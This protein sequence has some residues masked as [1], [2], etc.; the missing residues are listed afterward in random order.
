MNEQKFKEFLRMLDRDCFHKD[1]LYVCSFG[2]T[3]CSLEVGEWTL[4]KLSNDNK[5]L[6]KYKQWFKEVKAERL[7]NGNYAKTTNGGIA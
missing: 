5:H 3:S 1:G 4:L 7:T 6:K 2:K